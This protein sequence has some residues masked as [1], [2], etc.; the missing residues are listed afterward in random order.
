LAR[1]SAII[2][3]GSATANDAPSAE[4]VPS[5]E[6]VPSVEDV[7]ST[8]DVPSVEDVPSAEPV[9]SVEDIG[10]DLAAWAAAPAVQ[11]EAFAARDATGIEPD[12]E[13]DAGQDGRA[14][15]DMVA[16][17]TAVAVAEDQDD[18]DSVVVALLEPDAQITLA[19]TRVPAIVE[20][21]SAPA[22]PEGWDLPMAHVLEAAVP[23]P[24]ESPAVGD[25][26]SHARPAAASQRPPR[27]ARIT[28][29]RFRPAATRRPTA[30]S[31]AVPVPVIASCPYC[32]VLLEP[33]PE[34][35]RRC[36][37]CRQRIIVRRV[38][39]RQVFLTEAAVQVFEAERRRIANTGRW[40]RDRQRWLK[41]AASVGAPAGRIA[42]LERAV[43]SD[44]VV[45]DART[46]YETTVERQVRAA[47]RDRRWDT[48]ARLRRDE[49]L[50]RY[51]MAGSPVPPP[52]DVL[53][54]HRE[55]E[56]AALRGLGEIAKKADLIS[57]GCCD[58]CRAD[59]GRQFTISQELREPRLPHAGCPKGLCRCRWELTA[60]DRSLIG[61]YLRRHSRADRTAPSG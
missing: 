36:A 45:A 4:D 55:G 12:S 32:A 11:T 40:T 61:D 39:G 1:L 10:A 8:E 46:L 14:A 25:E 60:R 31:T 38:Q 49:A 22:D 53:A 44:A 50:S 24:T 26:P 7:P 6:D 58:T 20:H 30:Q 41:L 13:P 5:T 35:D 18:A 3:Q 9:A 29:A 17:M 33:P 43:L 34:A 16:T 2:D 52:D 56:L 28:A 59:D 57:A 37:R 51:R 48:V 27:V 21:E 42:R 19:T 15:P 23:V 47:R 54:P